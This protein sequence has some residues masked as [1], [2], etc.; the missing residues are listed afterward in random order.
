AVLQAAAVVGG[1]F[2]TGVLEAMGS[3][4]GQLEER[5]GDLCEAEFLVPTDR[6]RGEEYAFKHPLLQEVTY[7]S[8]LQARREA[9]HRA[10]GEAIE[11]RLLGVAPGVDAMLAYHFGR[12]GAPERAEEYLFRAGDEA[13]RS[14]A[15]SEALHFFQE[16]SK[17]YFQ[18]HGQGGNPTKKSRLEKSVGLALF[19]GGREP[20]AVEHFDRALEQL[21]VPVSKS[22]LAIQL[23]FLGDLVAVL[24]RL[25]LPSGRARRAANEGER[26][27]IEIMFQRALSQSIAAPTRFLFDSLATLRRIARLDPRTIP[28][29]GGKYAGT[30]GIFSY[31]GLS[32]GIGRRFLAQ[33]DALL[34]GRVDAP[35]YL[36][37]RAMRFI[38]HYLAGDWSE[39]HEVPDE[40]LDEKV[41][42]GRFW[43]VTTYLGFLAEKRIRCGEFERARSLLQRGF[44]IAD[45]FE[46][47]AARL[48]AMGEQAYLLLEQGRFEEAVATADD[49]Y[50]ESPQDL[51]HLLALALRA[52][53]QVRAGKLEDAA[54]SLARGDAILGAMKL[55]QAIPY[56]V[57][58]HRTARYHA[59]LA[60][61]EADHADRASAKQL[62]RSRRAAL[63][64]VAKVAGWRPRVFRLVGREAW[65]RGRKSSAERWWR[66]SLAEAERLGTRPEQ[67]R[68]LHEIGLRVGSAGRG[69]G[70]QRGAEYLDAATRLYG[71]LRLGQ[72]LDR[73]ERGALP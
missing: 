62:R 59:E 11:Q 42:A 70:G 4:D 48:T 14:A 72:E 27:I 6:S 8:L 52:E 15:S 63:G 21:G 44:E 64:S 10:A 7:D 66:R 34:E 28:G 32:F 3:G 47:Q 24:G 69:P 12:G 19:N 9:L 55:G 22:L 2:H 13:A 40:V 41:R 45:A 16:A 50:E 29:A 35:D 5:L 56:H 51:L 39:A 38:H 25:Y 54:A 18:L 30:V 53:V 57:S 1:T 65:L 58:F 67:A 49:Y 23:R 68:T 73:L 60:T 61:L 46:Y 17:L 26:E 71:E 43:E 33:A 37:Y 31:G 36:Y 20:E